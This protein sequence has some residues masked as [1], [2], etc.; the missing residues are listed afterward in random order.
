MTSTH[1]FDYE[2]DG[3]K[4]R[5]PVFIINNAVPPE[6]VDELLKKYPKDVFQVGKHS[7]A[8]KGVDQLNIIRKSKVLFIDEPQ[9]DHMLWGHMARANWYFTTRYKINMAETTQLTRY[10][11]DEKGHYNWHVDGGPNHCHARIPVFEEP[12]HSGEIGE[13]LLGGTVRKISCSVLLNDDFEG[14][15][16]EVRYFNHDGIENPCVDTIDKFKPKKGQAI[17]FLS[18]L[19]HRVAPVTKGTRYSLVKWFCG[20]PL[21]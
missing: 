4:F 16:F 1:K 19:C 18:D 3:K 8:A 9:I 2:V 20:P 12:K 6:T 7:S 10:E 15:D 13:P 5:S 11:G 17:Y 14:G 21:V